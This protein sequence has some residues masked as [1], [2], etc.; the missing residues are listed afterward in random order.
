MPSARTRLMLSLA[1]F[2]P[3]VALAGWL[4]HGLWTRHFF[5]FYDILFNIDLPTRYG[6]FAEGSGGEGLSL[7]HPNLWLVHAPVR[8][9]AL[10]MAKSGLVTDA[11]ALRGT[12][13][14]WVT[15]LALGLTAVVLLDLFL[16]LGLPPARA[17]LAALLAALSFSSLLFG[18]ITDHFAL[19]GLSIALTFWLAERSLRGGRLP[20]LPWL[21]TGFFVTAVTVTNAAIFAIVLGL[22]AW[23]LRPRA[24]RAAALILAGAVGGNLA[25]H[26]LVN[27]VK[28]GVWGLHE[29]SYGAIGLDDFFVFSL[30][31]LADL[32]FALLNSLSPLGYLRHID[33]FGRLIFSFAGVHAGALLHWLP[34]A[35]ALALIG[36]GVWAGLRSGGRLGFMTL[37]ALAVVAFNMAFH[38]V[39]GHE[40]FLYSQHWLVALVLPAAAALHPAWR[41][42]RLAAALAPAV[43]AFMLWNNLATLRAIMDD[44]ELINP[45]YDAVAVG[46]VQSGGPLAEGEAVHNPRPCPPPAASI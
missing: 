28:E 43:V 29:T 30:A 35:L 21:A 45:Y 32:P 34:G 42:S 7:M 27:F 19:G 16:H 3:L 25:L 13:A 11:A 4:G 36:A 5:D 10:L 39:W 8:V 22:T 23:H 12:L 44:Y 46:L 17:M 37:A 1:L 31:R 20:W 14:L 33:G 2:A 18:S 38:A 40:Y 41:P 26:L 6:L 15:P 9:L 24:L